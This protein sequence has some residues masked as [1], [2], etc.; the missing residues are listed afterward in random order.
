MN[1]SGQG[2]NHRFELLLAYSALVDKMNES[3]EPPSGKVESEGAKAEQANKR[4]R[5]FHREGGNAVS[6][7]GF[8]FHWQWRSH[9]SRAPR[10]PLAIS[11][12]VGTR[13]QSAGIIHRHTWA[14]GP[15]VV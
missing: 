15:E 8:S 2:T 6:Y 3:L 5:L 10:S 13:Q 1:D 4:D 7:P 14:F 11:Q 12:S 9:S